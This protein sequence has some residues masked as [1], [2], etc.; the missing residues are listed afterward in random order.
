MLKVA[1]LQSNYLPWRGYFDIVNDV[2]VFVFY[3]EVQ[4]TA[5]DWR[6][7]NRLYSKQGLTPW[8]TVPC[9]HRT[10]QVINEV[11]INNDLNWAYEHWETIRHTY[12]RAPFFTK[13]KSF[14]EC[15]YLMR[16]W[17]R[18]SELNQHIIKLIASDLLGIT[19][20]FANSNEYNSFGNKSEKL[21][22]L[23]RSIGCNEYTSG[24]AAKDYLDETAF[25][26]E[27]IK[28]IWKDYAGYPEYNQT[29]LP[30]ENNV[31]I[32]DLLMNTGDDAPYYIWGWRDMKKL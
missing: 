5:R 25:V 28:V 32:I 15:I 6:N 29:R 22:S 2:D 13:Y 1:V 3:D 23:L 31:S 8:L 27:G 4:Y 18:L 20:Q 16:K 19:T 26:Q 21:L 12:A 11:L 17:E 30:F 9:R 10:N 24:P 7:R 14:F